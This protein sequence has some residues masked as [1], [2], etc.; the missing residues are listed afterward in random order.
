MLND[1]IPISELSNCST[2]ELYYKLLVVHYSRSQEEKEE[3][4]DLLPDGWQLPYYAIQEF[5]KP[6]VLVFNV[7]LRLKETIGFVEY[8]WSNQSN[9]PRQ[10]QI[11][12]LEYNSLKLVLKNEILDN[13]SN[14]SISE[15]S[16]FSE[17]L[18][19][20]EKCGFFDENQ[21]ERSEY[22]LNVA[23]EFI[24]AIR[25]GS[26]NK[27]FRLCCNLSVSELINLHLIGNYQIPLHGYEKYYE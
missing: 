25:N 15:N 12:E 4:L 26:I 1:G 13:D 11:S 6:I 19:V 10:Y 3:A 23:I 17:S 5:L 21:T 27:D 2:L 24:D 22:M 9:Y 20:L 7:T 14:Y 8:Y 16:E 18:T